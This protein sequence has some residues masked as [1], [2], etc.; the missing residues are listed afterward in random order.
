MPSGDAAVDEDLIAD[1]ASADWG[2][3][4]DLGGGTGHWFYFSFF[5]IYFVLFDCFI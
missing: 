1:L 2:P 5:V 3:W 4:A